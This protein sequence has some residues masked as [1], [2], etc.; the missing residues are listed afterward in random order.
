M[1][2]A[3]FIVF[4][5]F[6][7]QPGS[8]NSQAFTSPPPIFKQNLSNSFRIVPFRNTYRKSRSSIGNH[9][10]IQDVCRSSGRYIHRGP[11][12]VFCLFSSFCLSFSHSHLHYMPVSIHPTRPMII[13]AMPSTIAVPMMLTSF[14]SNSL[15]KIFISFAPSIFRSPS[16]ARPH[17]WP[18][19]P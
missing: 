4:T 16:A 15:V 9:T 3:L 11:S 18:R 1:R 12:G 5:L 14:S 19:L 17:V 8:Q 7:L 2:K 6:L 13:N 10:C